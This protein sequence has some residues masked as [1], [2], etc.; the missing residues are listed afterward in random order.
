MDFLIEPLSHSFLIRGLIGGLL[1]ALPCAVLS[2]FVVWRGMSFMGDAL[3][4]SVLPGIVLAYVLGI[5][6]FWGALAAGL[7]AVIGI[8]YISRRNKLNEDAAIGVV[9]A[10]FFALGLLMLGRVASNRDLKHILFGNILGIS[11]G[12]L[13]LMS[14][15]TLLVISLTFLSLKEIVTASFDPAHARAIGLSPELVRYFIL[16]LLALTTVA[17]IQTVGV[18][19]VLALLVTPGA[20]ASLIY[21]TVNRIIAFSIVLA[22]LATITGFYISYYA[23]T[24]S[25]PAIVLTLTLMFLLCA[26]ISRFGKK[27]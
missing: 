25:G 26:A 19:L 4:H 27:S 16:I 23:D 22:I 6:L 15:V 5:N 18:V 12:D 2:G 24:A 1:T 8:G 20:A 3:A 9:F 10:G 7:F 13:I 17:A 14:I 11:E 21:R